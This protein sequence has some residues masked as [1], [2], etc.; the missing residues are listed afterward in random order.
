MFQG[1]RQLAHQGKETGCQWGEQLDELLPARSHRLPSEADNKQRHGCAAGADGQ[2]LEE[3][4]A[5]GYT[6]HELGTNSTLS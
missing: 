2:S 3:Q 4:R 6:W 1:W 5:P